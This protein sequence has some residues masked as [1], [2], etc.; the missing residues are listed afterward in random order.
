MRPP[1]HTNDPA[2]V[3]KMGIAGVRA[4]RVYFTTDRELA[5]AF[6]A[7]V[8]VGAGHSALYRVQ[9]LDEMEVDPDFPSVGFQ[10]KQ[11]L[12]L[13]VAETD[14]TLS[15]EE[16]LKR[17]QPYLTWADGRLIWNAE[18]R[19]QLCPKWAAVGLTQLD[20]DAMFRPWTPVEHAENAIW[21]WHYDRQSKRS[22]PNVASP[23][24]G[25]N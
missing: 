15:R 4:D 23:A 20:V 25:S 21:H 16:Q 2:S 6:A 18:G 10:A 7:M 1:T 13:E 17:Q 12:I 14:V 3:S 11:A 5:R 8:R 19:L 9:P 22:V 24:R